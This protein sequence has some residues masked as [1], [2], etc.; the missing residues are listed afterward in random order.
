M[1]A[2]RRWRVKEAP[3][4][5]RIVVAIDPAATSGEDSGETGIIVA[6][7][8]AAS[9]LYVLHDASM[10]GTPN[11]WVSR[12]IALYREYKADRVVAEAN[13]GGDLI[14]SM[15]RGVDRNVSYSTVRA[16]RGKFV[17]AEPVSAL[18]ER[19]LVKRAAPQE[20]RSEGC[21]R[22]PE[23]VRAVRDHRAG[24]FLI[25]SLDITFLCSAE[26]RLRMPTCRVRVLGRRGPNVGLAEG[27]TGSRP[28]TGEC[29]G[30]AADPLLD[31]T[32]SAAR[33]SSAEAIIR[34]FTPAFVR[35]RK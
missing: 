21:T 27:D 19:G 2:H 32:G 20:P 34:Y 29:P 18:Y 8:D 13:N 5:K 24:R 3:A 26:F 35:S 30:D 33:L 15:V 17:R 10:R 1:G 22:I 28:L 16:T 7:T 12:V 4:L 31:H 9:D 23:G 25:L 6:G 14:E 11:E